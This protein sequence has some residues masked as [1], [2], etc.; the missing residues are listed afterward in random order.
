MSLADNSAT[1]MADRTND[2]GPNPDAFMVLVDLHSSMLGKQSDGELHATSTVVR[3]G[4]RV[5]VIRTVVTGTEEWRLAE[6][7][8]THIPA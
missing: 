6:V 1:Y 5:T 3:C 8:T 4:R 7:I 2:D